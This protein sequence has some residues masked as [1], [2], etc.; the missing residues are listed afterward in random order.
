MFKKFEEESI[1]DNGKHS[2]SVRKQP[3]KKPKENIKNP[4]DEPKA[5]KDL[6]NK[7]KPSII[8]KGSS[9]V[10]KRKSS[11]DKEKISGEKESDDDAMGKKKT[12]IVVKRSTLS[13]NHRIK[14]HILTSRYKKRPFRHDYNDPRK[15]LNRSMKRLGSHKKER[16]NSLED[17]LNFSLESDDI[18]NEFNK[19]VPQR[20]NHVKKNKVKRPSKSKRKLNRSYSDPKQK[21]NKKLYS[22]N[23]G[24]F[25]DENYD[26]QEYIRIFRNGK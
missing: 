21:N 3:A 22:D 16:E 6:I 8:E 17:L 7:K 15:K 10:K 20:H 4:L 14:P 23:F 2:T 13:K 18:F 12:Q 25:G 5:G 9:S 24:F 19:P 11:P 1:E 26:Y